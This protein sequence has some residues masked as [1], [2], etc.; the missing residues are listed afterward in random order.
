MCRVGNLNKKWCEE[1]EGEGEGEG[2]GEMENE[3][4]MGGPES[5]DEH[6]M[7]A[8]LTHFLS[9]SVI[10]NPNHTFFWNLQQIEDLNQR[11]EQMMEEKPKAHNDMPS[12]QG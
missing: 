3:V 11:L 6:V 5:H 7:V 10:T 8:F 9:F 4:E 2:E 1:R 12:V